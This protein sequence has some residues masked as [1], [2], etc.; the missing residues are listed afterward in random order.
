MDA[1]GS[2][3]QAA[4]SERL[5]TERTAKPTGIGSSVLAQNCKSL[6]MTLKTKTKEVTDRHRRHSLHLLR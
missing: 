2:E 5:L 1:M 4:P 6:S 3:A